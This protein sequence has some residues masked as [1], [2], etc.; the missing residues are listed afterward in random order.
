M[1]QSCRV[2]LRD[3]SPPWTGPPLAA[4]DSEHAVAQWHHELSQD[5]H[6]SKTRHQ[7]RPS[8]RH[9]CGHSQKAHSSS[10]AVTAANATNAVMRSW[11]MTAG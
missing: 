5:Q 11:I 8:V 6:T 7:K 2:G 10:E 1:M 3:P 9:S 4:P